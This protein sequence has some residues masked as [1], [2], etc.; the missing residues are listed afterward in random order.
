MDELQNQNQQQEVQESAKSLRRGEV[1]KSRW[2]SW[3]KLALLLAAVIAVGFFAKGLL[4]LSETVFAFS[5]TR[6]VTNI[7][8]SV[9]DLKRLQQI[10]V[11]QI[12]LE[13]AFK[14]E[15]VKVGEGRLVNY[16][17]KKGVY[18]W[19]GNAKFGVDLS[20]MDESSVDH[21]NGVIYLPKVKVIEYGLTSFK[22]WY[23]NYMVEPKLLGFE[24]G[25]LDSQVPEEYKNLTFRMMKEYAEQE[26]RKDADNFL[27]EK[28]A[29]L[30]E[31]VVDS[32]EKVMSNFI[33]TKKYKIVFRE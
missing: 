12:S 21:D 1:V 8:I 6:R 28:R 11:F 18:I 14:R 3:F 33:D 30:E 10:V 17:L 19:E 5:R 7:S 22:V 16:I 26:L 23:E 4:R 13:D 32:L 27:T 15:D 24:L 9:I 29:M 20:E 25:Y 31:L 2:L